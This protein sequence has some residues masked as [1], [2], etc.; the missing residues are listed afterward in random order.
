ME[1]EN[2]TGT[3]PNVNSDGSTVPETEMP[4]KEGDIIEDTN[5]LDGENPKYYLV[6][7][8]G[9]KILIEEGKIFP[10]PRILDEAGRP[11][12]FIIQDGKKIELSEVTN[13]ILPKDI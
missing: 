6:T 11:T 8:N 10:D 1:G 4:Y 12:F 7:F 9:E 3:D 2:P 5:D 13:K